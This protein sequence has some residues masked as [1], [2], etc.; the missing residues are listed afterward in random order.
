VWPRSG[1]KAGGD[2]VMPAYLSDLEALGTARDA[3]LSALR[4]MA[5]RGAAADAL[6]RAIDLLDAQIGR[7]IAAMQRREE[8][9]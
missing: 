7:E 6:K 3:L 4:R 5:G 8:A 1:K 2:A 9:S